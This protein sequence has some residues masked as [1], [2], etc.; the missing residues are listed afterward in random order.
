LSQKENFSSEF[1]SE[2]I[3]KN[4]KTGSMNFAELF[5]PKGFLDKSK[6]NSESK[7][8][9]S[10][11]LTNKENTKTDFTEKS[12]RTES[13][14]SSL[15]PGF[16]LLS[17]LNDKKVD[18]ISLKPIVRAKKV[19]Q[20]LNSSI[21]DKSENAQN[22]KK[23]HIDLLVAASMK[24]MNEGILDEINK[25]ISQSVK[26]NGELSDNSDSTSVLKHKRGKNDSSHIA[27]C[28]N[29]GCEQKGKRIGKLIKVENCTSN[30]Q[31][32][33]LCKKCHQAFKD[34][35]YCYYCS[36]I[37][38]TE[39]NDNRSWIQCDFCS[40]WHHVACEE[41]KGK[42]KNIHKNN[43]KYKCPHCRILIPARKRKSQASQ[44]VD[45][46]SRKFNCNLKNFRKTEDILH[47]THHEP[48]KKSDSGVTHLTLLS[49]NDQKSL[50]N[51]WV[52]MKS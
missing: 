12:E 44:N 29:E 18:H 11:I 35:Q 50:Y 15:S 3:Q 43:Q 52:K 31:I 33:W 19:A 8:M 10:A 45:I 6:T 48:P 28:Q 1:L 41:S 20:T 46:Y 23:S 5:F 21:A 22:E 9:K 13:P 49:M 25:V 27:K 51:D 36:F 26:S 16:D 2:A 37:Y 34:R 30:C 42:Y 38:T 24:L 14:D 17:Q 4:L 7:S 32:E 40:L 47:L 39:T